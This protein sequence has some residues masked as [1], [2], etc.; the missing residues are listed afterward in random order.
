ML[1]TIIIED[2]KNARQGLIDSLANIDANVNVVAQL[3]TVRESIESR[4]LHRS[5]LY[6]VMFS[7]RTASHLKYSA[8]SRSEHR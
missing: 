1:N 7:W 4:C 5:I 8:R 2:E 3:C 6:F